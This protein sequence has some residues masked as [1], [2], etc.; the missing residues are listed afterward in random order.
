MS[1]EGVVSG[2]EWGVCVVRSC[3]W[4]VRVVCVVSGSE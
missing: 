2:S 4:L 3:V 1:D